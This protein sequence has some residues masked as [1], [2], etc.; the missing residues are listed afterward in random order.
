MIPRCTPYSF[1]PREAASTLL[2]FHHFTVARPDVK[3]T[4]K[5]TRAQIEAR[6]EK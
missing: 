2:S 1:G 3:R 5:S 6:P 4:G